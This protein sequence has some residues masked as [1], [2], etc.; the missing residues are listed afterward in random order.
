VMNESKKSDPA[1]V[2]VKPTNKAGSDSVAEPVEPRAG[3]EGNAN[4]QSTRRAQNR[5]RV[6]QALGAYVRCRRY[7]GASTSSTRGGSRVRESCL[8]GSVRGAHSNVR[9]YRER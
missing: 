5:D 3:A 2:A 6:P 8:L 4:Q 7:R 1:V 9:P